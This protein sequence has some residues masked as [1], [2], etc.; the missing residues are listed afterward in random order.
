MVNQSPWA[1]VGSSCAE[2]LTKT[3]GLTFQ[4]CRTENSQSESVT[5]G[6][7]HFHADH[8][9][10][11]L[12]VGSS[13]SCYIKRVIL[14]STGA[15]RSWIVVAVVH[16]SLPWLRGLSVAGTWLCFEFELIVTFYHSTASSLGIT[17]L[18]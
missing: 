6:A 3:S 8:D 4:L 17:R 9:G 15:Q 12:L 14:V 2:E 18:V 1:K 13:A 5:S 7:G 11:G 16:L 10:S